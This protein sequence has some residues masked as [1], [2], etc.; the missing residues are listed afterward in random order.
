[1]NKNTSRATVV[2]GATMA[3]VMAG[4]AA[5]SAAPGQR[6]DRMPNRGKAG[7]GDMMGGQKMPG[8]P[9]ARGEQR[10]MGPGLRGGVDDFE[11][12]ETSVQTADGITVRRVEQGAVDGAAADALTFSLGSGETVTVVIDDETQLFALEEQEQ[13]RRGRSRSMMAP[14]E[15]EAAGIEA[16]AEIVVWSDS[17]D[18]EDFVAARVVVQ[19]ANS[20]ETEDTEDAADTE[21]DEEVAEETVADEPA[22]EGAAA[23]DA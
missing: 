2:I 14:T 1:M 22:T 9:G 7:A 20:D 6:D 18:G 11:R 12:R 5:V 17:E 10:G 21:A 19:P 16:G 15:I 8:R 13:V 23:T 3:L 4:T